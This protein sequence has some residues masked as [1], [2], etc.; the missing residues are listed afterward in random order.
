MTP[1]RIIAPVGSEVVVL[2][3]ICGG[4]GYFATNQP[5]EWMLSNDSVGQIIEVGGMHH[6]TFNKVVPP[7]ANKFDG[8][9]AHGRT[10]LKEIV[11]TRGTPTPCD[12]I[13][14][15]KGQTFVSISSASPGTTYL[16]GVAPRAESWDRRRATTRIYWV[17]GTWAVPA[18]IRA[19]AGTVSPL[20][21]V[22]SQADGNGG[23]D[24]WKVR[25]TIVGGAPAEFAPAGSQTAEATSSSSGEATVQIRQRAG[26]FDPGT[27]Q[28]RVDIVRPAVLGERE[29]L[30]ESGITSVT[31]SAPALTIRA[32]GDA[33]AGIDKPFNYRIEV[34][35]PGDQLARD[36]VVR[37]KDFDPD[38]EYISATPKPTQYGSQYE[39]EIGDLPPGSPPQIIDVQLRTKKRGTIGLCF[40]VASDSDRLRT[41][42]C[43]QTEVSAPC[44]G[45]EIEGPDT[46][47]VG[48]ELVYEI[49]LVNQCEEPLR[50]IRLRI[51]PDAA[52]VADGTSSRVIEATIPELGFGQRRDLPLGL[53]A[54][55]PGRHCFRLEVTTE[56]GDASEALECVVVRQQ[57]QPAVDLQLQGGAPVRVGERVTVNA[58][59]TNTGNTALNA[60]SLI[61]EYPRSLSPKRIS[62]NAEPVLDPNEDPSSPLVM[63]LGRLEPGDEAFVVLQYEGLQV[64]PDA[65][66][67][68][69]VT[70]SE[71]A[72]NTRGLPIRVE[73]SASGDNRGRDPNRPEFTDPSRPRTDS[74]GN[75]VFPSTPTVPRDR[76]AN[77]T[78]PEPRIEIP[79]EER[80]SPSRGLGI[81][82]QL[83]SEAISISGQQ[84]AAVRF[85][86]TNNDT[87]PHEDVD[88]SL[89]MPPGLR[90]LGTDFGDTRLGIANAVT[91]QSS[92]IDYTRRQ[93]LRPGDEIALIIGVAGQQPGR[94]TIGVQ[95]ESLQSRAVTDNISISVNP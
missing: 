79:Q 27:T 44:I 38:I 37:T 30:V 94:H 39:W 60:V 80:S 59:V 1:S 71:S 43:A 92:R 68:F 70:S 87:V 75:P 73:P 88:I 63:K 42:A 22:I 85:V 18:P 91:E 10:G 82:M 31:W 51:T 33:T 5:L 23:I 76:P 54:T 3:G 72:S 50:N 32:I 4:D 66:L 90:F 8:Q 24:G 12:D 89:S 62:E 34:T 95:V 57:G 61:N 56:N 35:N 53:L 84:Q 83:G 45:L 29:L 40:E 21:T 55:A 58:I 69:S 65:Q 14:L 49:G 41:E 26:Q 52:L 48:E 16:T 15:R 78:G 77:P 86:I 93:V 46:A 64:D 19:T 74:D 9:Y 67:S 7:Q 13:Q 28:V 17:D 6:P 2:A 36:V 47:R 81:R 20:T 11:L 25:Y